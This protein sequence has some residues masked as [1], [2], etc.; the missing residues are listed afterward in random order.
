LLVVAPTLSGVA[1]LVHEGTL[2]SDVIT[3]EVYGFIKSGPGLI[4]G[5]CMRRAGMDASF[6]GWCCSLRPD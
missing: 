2:Q 6:D 5:E 3:E 4:K 1:E